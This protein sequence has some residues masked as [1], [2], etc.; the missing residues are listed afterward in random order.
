MSG[1]RVIGGLLAVAMVVIGGFLALAGM[2]QVGESADTSAA[3]AI[4]GSFVGG[5]GLALMFTVLKRRR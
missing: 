1:G 3:W 4:A 2:G 5:L